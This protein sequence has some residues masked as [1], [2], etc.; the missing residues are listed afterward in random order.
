MVLRR[1]CFFNS[2][3]LDGSLGPLVVEGR[4]DVLGELAE[5]VTEV[6]EPVSGS[7]S[8]IFLQLVKFIFIHS[9]THKTYKWALHRSR[10]EQQA[11]F[12]FNTYK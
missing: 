10:R 5:D 12:V 4:G 11:F 3:H 2:P 1:L 8:I 6:V 9:L 7:Y